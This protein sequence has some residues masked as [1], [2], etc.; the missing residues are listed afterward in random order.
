MQKSKEEWIEIFSHAK[1]GHI[2]WDGNA[3]DPY[4][5]E[6]AYEGSH[7]FVKHA[8]YLGF[9]KR[10]SHILD[11][12]CGNGRFGIALSDLDVFYEGIDPMQPCIE[13]CKV[14]F[15]GMD[16]FHFQYADIYNAVSNPNGQVKPD[17]YVIPFADNQFDDV[18]CYSVLTHLEKLSVAKHYMS[19]I[20]RVLKPN[21]RFFVTCYR[22]PPDPTP[23]TNINRT[24]YAESDILNLMQGL[25]ILHTYGGHSGQFYDQWALFCEKRRLNRELDEMFCHA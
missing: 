13:F 17:N 22:S 12:G 4:N 2:L 9:F 8:T 16:R 10:G 3:P 19:E 14:A 15:Q 18:I 20:K 7:N 25:N 1:D 23:D 11:L 6:H 5:P 21:G 24:V